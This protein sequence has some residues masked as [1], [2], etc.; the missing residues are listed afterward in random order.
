SYSSDS[1]ACLP[2]S[3]V[4]L[5]GTNDTSLFSLIFTKGSNASLEWSITITSS[6]LSSPENKSMIWSIL[7]TPAINIR[8]INV[9]IINDFDFNFD[10]Y[11]LVYTILILCIFFIIIINVDIVY[12]W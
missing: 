6:A 8:T 12:Y 4:S 9:V 3:S 10:K 5:K 2:A 7:D 1:T 11:V